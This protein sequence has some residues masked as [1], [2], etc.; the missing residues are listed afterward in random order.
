MRRQW[1]HQLGSTL[2]RPS[3]SAYFHSRDGYEQFDAGVDYYEVLG[4]PKH[5][6]KKDIK[7]AYYRLALKYH[8]DRTQGSTTK[9]FLEI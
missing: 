1:L 4:V 2:L 7:F 6:K 5:A 9:K 3:Q 8:P